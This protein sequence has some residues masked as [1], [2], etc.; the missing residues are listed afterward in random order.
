MLENNGK[1]RLLHQEFITEQRVILIVQLKR[2]PKSKIL[3]II[4]TH[5][6]KGTCLISALSIFG[7]NAGIVKKSPLQYFGG[8]NMCFVYAFFTWKN[9][10][11]IYGI[12]LETKKKKIR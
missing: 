10:P 5:F 1:F 2:L 8:I 11:S 12:S 9:F 7:A 4:Q 6:L 3:V